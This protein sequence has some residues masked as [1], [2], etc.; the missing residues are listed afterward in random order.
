MA[1]TG[2]P[3]PTKAAGIAVFRELYHIILSCVHVV[4]YGLIGKT[5]LPFQRVEQLA[6]FNI[7]Q[8]ALTWMLWTEEVG[9]V[10][11]LMGLLMACCGA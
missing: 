2:P 9:L 1:S 10:I 11:G 4:L 8:L 7:P 3:I 6:G 5:W